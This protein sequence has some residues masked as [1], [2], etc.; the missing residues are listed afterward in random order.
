MSDRSHWGVAFRLRIPRSSSNRYHQVVE[1]A[2]NLSG[3][4]VAPN[5]L[6]VGLIL[7]RLDLI[8]AASELLG[9]CYRWK[10]VELHIEGRAVSPYIAH[11]RLR[12]FLENPAVTASSGRGR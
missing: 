1:L 8:E 3:Y 6:E 12:G 4:W 2:E 11:W 7:H 9:M 10:H 5:V